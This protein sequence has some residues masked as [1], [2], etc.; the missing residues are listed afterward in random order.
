MK[1]SYYV[2]TPDR[3]MEEAN[4]TNDQKNGLSGWF[5]QEGHLVA[6]YMYANGLLEGDVKTYYPSGKVMSSEHYVN[7]LRQ[8]KCC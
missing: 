8:G 5:T 2:E 1:R 7:N 6:E 3:I 4:Y